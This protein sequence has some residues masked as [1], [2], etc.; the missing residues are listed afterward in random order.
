MKTI[1]MNTSVKNWR[2]VEFKEQKLEY[3]HSN[4]DK[5]LDRISSLQER[6]SMCLEKYLEHQKILLDLE[7]RKK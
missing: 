3:H 6:N 5:E 2:R 4:F 1:D 7:L